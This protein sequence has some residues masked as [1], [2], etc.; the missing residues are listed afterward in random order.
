MPDEKKSGENG[1]KVLTPKKKRDLLALFSRQIA[2]KAFDLQY[3][4]M[5][6]RFTVVNGTV[7]E[8]H[9]LAPEI[10]LRPY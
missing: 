2:E 7:R 9:V 5:T 8:C 3:G 6:V 4:N 1:K 10:K